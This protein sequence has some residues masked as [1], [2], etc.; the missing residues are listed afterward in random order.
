MTTNK[1]F[2]TEIRHNEWLREAFHMFDATDPKQSAVGPDTKIITP[3]ANINFESKHSNTDIFD[4]GVICAWA[5]GLI[6]S[7]S[8]F[9][10]NDQVDYI[11]QRCYDHENHLNDHLSY[12][13]AETTTFSMSK[14][15]YN[16][17]LEDKQVLSIKIDAPEN[18]I[19]AAFTSG[20]EPKSHYIICGDNIFRASE[21][22]VHD[23]LNLKRYGVPALTNEHL[24]TYEIRSRRGSTNA[25]GIARVTARISYK[26]QRQ[27]PQ[28]PIR[29]DDDFKK[30][31]DNYMKEI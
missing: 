27:L 11:Q 10:S 29:L 3:K 9:Y 28:T 14:V 21:K 8:T 18:L 19:E 24:S 30:I 20:I 16:K 4:G 23:P 5:N 17:M 7:I 13:G 15:D 25:K 26:L 22:E 31:I 6:K 2:T 12:V 1:G